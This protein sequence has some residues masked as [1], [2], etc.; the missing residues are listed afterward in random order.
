MIN[1]SDI[2][3]FWSWFKTNMYNLQSQ[4]Y[5]NNRFEELDNKITNF[6]LR[7]EVGPGKEKANS[8]TI[9]PNGDLEKIEL[10]K[11]FVRLSPSLDSWEF[12]CFKQPKQNWY[13]LELPS[14]DINI[15]AKDWTY[16]ILKY[17]DGKKE[18][19]IKG[20]SLNEIDP[21]YKVD[22]AEM[23]LIN[24]IGEER[25]MT[26]LDFIDVLSPDDNTYELQDITELIEQLDYI[27][28]DRLN[29]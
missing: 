1:T 6:E 29:T 24:L 11:E 3:S 25:M 17:K 15:T 9:S 13:K 8:L 27:K 28:N 4:K 18:I 19:L 21:D 20:D 26:E 12:Y 22:I 7:W 10:V 23:V 14:Y 16:T 5:P 2:N